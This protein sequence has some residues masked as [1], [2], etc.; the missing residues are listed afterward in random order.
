MQ[1]MVVKTGQHHTGVG[2]DHVLGVQRFESLGDVCYP[3]VDANVGETT[4]RQCGATNQQEM[5]RFSTSA[6]T[7]WLSSPSPA[8]GFGNVGIRGTS[9][10][11]KSTVSGEVA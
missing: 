3:L 4:I 5:S 11:C 2:V 6:C 10:L 8:A 9:W 7:R 1:V